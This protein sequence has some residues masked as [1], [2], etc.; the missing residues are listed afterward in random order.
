MSDSQKGILAILISGDFRRC[1]IK[2]WVTC[3]RLNYCRIALSGLWCFL[4][5]FS[6]FKGDWGLCG[7]PFPTG[8]A[9][10]RFLRH[11]CLLV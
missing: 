7:L 2:Y 8:A 3:R 11:L 1:I 5:L 4:L 10:P 9:R 6:V